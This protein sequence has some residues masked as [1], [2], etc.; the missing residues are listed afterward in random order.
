MMDR[1]RLFGHLACFAAYVIFGVNIIVCKDLTSSN[2]ISPFGIFS[3]RA[4]GASIMFWLLS[5]LMPKERVDRADLP[6]IFAASMLGL[7]ITQSSFLIGIKYI[8]PIDWSVLTVITPIAT[9]FVAAIF[10]GEPIT[11]KKASGVS[12]SFVGIVVLILSSSGNS[13]AGETTLFGV[14]MAFANVLSFSLYLGL[15]RPLIQ[16]Y[17]VVSFM[18]WSFL[19]S[20]ITSLPFTAK[21]IVNVDY[22]AFNLSY[23]LQL[24]FLI[25]FSTFVAYFLIPFGQK[26]VRPTAV[27]LYSYL[28]PIIAAAISIYLGMDRVTSTK[29][30]SAVAV[31]FG[32]I[33][34][35]RSRTK[36][37]I[38]R[39][40]K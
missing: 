19:F 30:L 26:S 2:L 10:Q 22:S 14:L 9:M 36:D 12:I 21:E 5:L 4:L 40:D 28:Q 38:E 15:F 29:I 11:F 31:V 20:L 33:L 6:K 18:K 39:V 32:V 13:S 25:I 7:L 23:S 1:S 34:V 16:K 37:Q 8:T 3:I 17:S 24:A 35:N 27:S